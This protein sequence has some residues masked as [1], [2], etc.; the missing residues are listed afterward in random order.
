MTTRPTFR[1]ITTPLDVDDG[2]LARLNDQLGV[3]ELVR[4][5]PEGPASGQGA[6]QNSPKQEP[7]PSPS[8]KANDPPVDKKQALASPGPVE[9]LSVELPGYLTDAMKRQATE[10]RTSVRYIIMRGLVAIGFDIAP[11]DLVPDARRLLRKPRKR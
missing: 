8:R 10:Q 11:A 1:S 2:A 5:A 6:G 9:K 7:R 3:P 4:S